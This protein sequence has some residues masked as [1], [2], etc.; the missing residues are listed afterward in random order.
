MDIRNI[1][2]V[3]WRIV[4]CVFIVNGLSSFV[5]QYAA[6]TTTFGPIMDE[7]TLY[8]ATTSAVMFLWPV[9][10][11]VIGLIGIGASRFL[12]GLVARGLGSANR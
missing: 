2:T 4:G 11:I 10:S 8:S 6:I 7:E 5:I 12:A 9:L 3:I 1:A